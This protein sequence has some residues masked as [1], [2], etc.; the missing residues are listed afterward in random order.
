M[1]QRPSPDEDDRRRRWVRRIAMLLA[2]WLATWV[3]TAWL[4]MHPDPFGLL[5]GYAALFALCWFVYDYQV[6]WESTVWETDPIGHR[7]RSTSDSRIS[8]LSRL[9][10]DAPSPTS[11][12]DPNPSSVALQ[13]VLRDVA[14]DRLRVRAAAEG[15]VHLPD[16]ETLIARADPRLAEYLLAQPPPRTTAQTVTDIINRIEAL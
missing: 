5:A 2:C 13:G 7:L 12:G 14:I 15:A 3:L 11:N 10:S 1:T 4:R 16:D 6:R 8:Y 9:I